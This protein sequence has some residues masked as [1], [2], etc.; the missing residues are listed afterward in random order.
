MISGTCHC[1]AVA[2]E[3]SEAPPALIQCNCSL[4]RRNGA[5]WAIYDANRV[6]ISAEKSDVSEYVW[7][8]RTIRTLRCR[9]CGCVTH[10][11]S[12]QGEGTVGINFRNFDPEVIEAIATR[13]FDGAD[14]WA[15][16]DA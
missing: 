5:L 6:R 2:I 7:G 8:K 15:Y 12:L 3:L 16:V 14:T 9:H 10:W 4:C 1:G 13:R 11:E